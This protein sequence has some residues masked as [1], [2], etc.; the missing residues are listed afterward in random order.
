M[1]F[2][3]WIND[4]VTYKRFEDKCKKLRGVEADERQL[5]VGTSYT[6]SWAG[7]IP[8]T[9]D[10]TSVPKVSPTLPDGITHVWIFNIQSPERCLIWSDEHGWRDAMRHW[11]T[12]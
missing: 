9:F 10:C 3:E 1:A 12:E 2:V 5:F 11:S 6:T 7:F 4:L 8:L